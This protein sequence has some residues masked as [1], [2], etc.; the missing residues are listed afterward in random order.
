MVGGSETLTENLRFL[1]DGLG[2]PLRKYLLTDFWKSHLQ[3]YKKR[4]I[5]WLVQSPK[6]GFQALIYLHRY[7]KDSFHLVLNDYLREY[8]RKLRNGEES[9]RVQLRGM[10]EGTAKIQQELQ[11]LENRLH[12]LEQ[13]EREVVHPL[14]QSQIEIDLDDGVKVNYP[15]FYPALAKIAGL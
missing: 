11:K 7:T 12:E 15:K 13:W 8:M 1:E 10:D 2:K 9:L 5:Y 14:A 4:P 6:K 3:S